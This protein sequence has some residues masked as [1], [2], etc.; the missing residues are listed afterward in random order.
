MNRG[1]GK[2]ALRQAM[3]KDARQQKMNILGCKVS[4]VDM[5]AAVDLVEGF[6]FRGRHQVAFVPVSSVMAARKDAGFQALLN[7]AALALPDGMPLLWASRLL[8][9]P[10]PG[11]VAGSDFLLEFSK[12]AAAKGYSFFLMGGQPGVPEELARALVRLNPKLKVVGTCSPPFQQKFPPGVNQDIVR[13]I[14]Q[15]RPDVLWVGL[16]APK[17]ERWI[18]QNLAQLEVKVAVGVGAAFDICSGRFRRAPAWMRR[19]C[20][21]WLFRFMLEPK[22]LF[23]RYFLE[24]LPFVPL[25]LWQLVRGSWMARR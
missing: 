8:G 20:L 16:G 13:Q 19:C 17:Q 5:T 11:R 25:L 22:R 18:Q 6:L 1:H 14:N 23:R 15:A 10:I 7:K 24:G 2:A 3:C 12:L 21:E 4:R 9:R